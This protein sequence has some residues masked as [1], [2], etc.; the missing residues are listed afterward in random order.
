[1]FNTVYFQKT[2]FVIL[3]IA[4]R[5]CLYDKNKNVKISDFGLSREGDKFKM[6][7]YVFV[8]I[9]LIFKI[10]V[11]FFR[12]QRVPIKWIA[13]ECLINFTFTRPSDVFSFGVL[14]WEI[15]TYVFF[16][17][18]LKFYSNLLFLEMQQN[19]LKEK[20]LQKLKIW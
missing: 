14:I 6:T 8:N 12:T 2:T 5:N 11:F 18:V 16:C 13:P 17:Y 19:H 3:D 7:T 1:M 10:T 9:Y 15:W 20:R 4:A